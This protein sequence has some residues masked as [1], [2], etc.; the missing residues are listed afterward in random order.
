MPILMVYVVDNEPL[1]L[2]GIVPAIVDVFKRLGYATEIESLPIEDAFD[3]VAQKK[4]SVMLSRRPDV[5]FF[6]NHFGKDPGVVSFGFEFIASVKD[7]YPDVVFVLMTRENLQHN[8]FG[9]ATPH[10]DIIISKSR[11]ISEAKKSSLPGRNN[12]GDFFLSAF[13][14][15][16]HRAKIGEIDIPADLRKA[17]ESLRSRDKPRRPIDQRELE[18]LVE[19]VCYMGREASENHIDKVS[20]RKLEGGLSEAVVCTISLTEA[21]RPYRVPAVVKF[22]TRDNA[23]RE[24]Q[25]HQRYVKWVLPYTWRV[26]VIGS[27]ETE[28]FGEVCYSFAHGG[29]EEPIS[30]KT[31]IGAAGR[32]QVRDII[33]AVFDPDRQTWYQQRRK[34]DRDIGAYLSDSGYFSGASDRLKRANILRQT[35][36]E[37]CESNGVK[38]IKSQ[39][40]F[41]IEFE[42]KIVDLSNV[43]EKIFAEHWDIPACECICH[44]DLNAANIMVKPDS[45]DFA[46]IDFRH[47]GWHHQTRDFC[48]IEGAVRTSYPRSEAFR[49]FPNYLRREFDRLALEEQ[50]LASEP[51]TYIQFCLDNLEGDSSDRELVG[52]TRG[53]YLRNFPGATFKEYLLAQLVHAWWLLCYKSNWVTSQLEILAA[54]ILSLLFCLWDR[55]KIQR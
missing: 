19:Q 52:L 30:F 39:G 20:L 31:V 55:Q 50:R 24:L 29:A 47:T 5:V 51:G 45:S 25:N 46:F 7:K 11:F 10:P 6:D 44:G 12:Y 32:V 35:I 33:Q 40:A 3:R 26:D 37:I 28:H 2:K 43:E 36:G 27:G 42:D 9:K 15:L 41:L 34:I 4:L 54:E 13:Q 53:L 22:S 17:F 48:S 16:Y 49:S 18:S 21:Q 23:Q 1:Q 14:R 8:E 38:T